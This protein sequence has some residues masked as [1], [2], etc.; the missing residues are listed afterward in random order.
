MAK[1]Y[2]HRYSLSDKGKILELEGEF[3]KVDPEQ[4]RPHPN[5]HYTISFY[6]GDYS[7]TKE[8][9]IKAAQVRRDK[10]I[11]SLQKQIDK[12]KSLKFRVSDASKK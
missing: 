3:G 2:L 5:Y 11:E 6:K 8:E 4:F 10:K 12:L 9:A 1:I 7:L